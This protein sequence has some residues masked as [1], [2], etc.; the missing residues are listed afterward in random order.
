M[1]KREPSYTVGG[2]INWCSHYGKQFLKKKL[3]LELPYDPAILLLGIY[4]E[5]TKTLIQKDTC[6]PMF[7][8]ALFTIA[9]TWKQPKRPLKDEWLK[10]CIDID[11]DIYIHIYIYIKWNITQT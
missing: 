7:K 8:A 4:L 5:K 6:T 1:E 10:M 3:K 11:I 9:K 2:N